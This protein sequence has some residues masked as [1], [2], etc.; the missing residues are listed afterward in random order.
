VVRVVG[1]K[2]MVMT[3]NPS[4]PAEDGSHPFL[5]AKVHGILHANML[6][7]NGLVDPRPERM[8]FLWV[9]WFK[10]A[11]SDASSYVLHVVSFPPVT[12]DNAFGFLDPADIL[13]S[14]HIIRRFSEVDSL[15]QKSLSATAQDASDCSMYFVNP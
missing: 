2:A 6:Y 4:Y 11:G 12:D 10:W 8:D 5:Y 13:R 15:L 9:R 3:L 14:C 7:M 1:P